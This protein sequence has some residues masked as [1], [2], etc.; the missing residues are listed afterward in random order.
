MYLQESN[1]SSDPEYYERK[2]NTRRWSVV[3]VVC[4]CVE[5]LL[6]PSPS[7]SR[8]R[9]DQFRSEAVSRPDTTTVRLPA[10]VA[11]R[12]SLGRLVFRT[13]KIR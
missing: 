2:E 5:K 1:G 10:Y 4:V 3:R 11:G 9:R 7:E 13:P 8:E 12:S 6:S